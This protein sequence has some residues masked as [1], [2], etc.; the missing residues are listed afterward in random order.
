MTTIFA[1]DIA[2]YSRLMAADEE[3]GV[4]RLK[5]LRADIIDPRGRGKRRADCENHG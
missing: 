5:K 2:G 1:A 3:G 4:F